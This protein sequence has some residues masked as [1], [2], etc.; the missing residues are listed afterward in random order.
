MVSLLDESTESGSFPLGISASTSSIA[1]IPFIYFVASVSSAI[2]PSPASADTLSITASPTEPT[3]PRH[4][5][6]G[7]AI[8]VEYVNYSN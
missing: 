4:L 5:P 8:T 7:V 2:S 6:S 3:S 1:L